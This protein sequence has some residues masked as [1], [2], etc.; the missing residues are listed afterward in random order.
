MAGLVRFSRGVLLL[1]IGVSACSGGRIE[2]GVFYSPK[3]YRVNLPNG[4][5]QASIRDRADLV[6]TRVGFQAGI[7]VHATCE[8]K[9][10]ARPLPVLARHL[11]FGLEGRKPLEREEVT[12]AGRPGIRM[13]LEGLLDGMPV[14][15]EAFVLKDQKCVYDLLYTAPPADFA[16]GRG[17]FREFVG[18]FI[19]P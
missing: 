12:L 9:P 13:L 7:L 5:W 17:E 16:V 18:S 6:L 3:G 2:G 10:P 4:P 1:L 11:T 15:V 8:G 14:T 19:T